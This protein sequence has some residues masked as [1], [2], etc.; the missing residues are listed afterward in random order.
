MEPSRCRWVSHNQ[1]NKQKAKKGVISVCL[2]TRIEIY[3]ISASGCQS[4]GLGLT[5]HQSLSG[6]SSPVLA[7][8]G[9]SGFHNHVNQFF[10]TSLPLSSA[11]FYFSSKL[12]WWSLSDL[13]SRDTSVLMRLLG[14]GTAAELGPLA[15]QVRGLGPKGNHD[16][17]GHGLLWPAQP[18]RR[19]R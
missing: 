19:Q 15:G 8:V 10:L 12:R 5:A 13:T 16:G 2:W 18:G 17:Q 3:I 9:T 6:V 4:F 14:E 1:V 7:Y 11:W